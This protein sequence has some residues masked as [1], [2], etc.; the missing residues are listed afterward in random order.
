MKLAGS[1]GLSI[2]FTES[3]S[4]SLLSTFVPLL[5]ILLYQGSVNWQIKVLLAYSNFVGD[6]KFSML[7]SVLAVHGHYYLFYGNYD[8]QDH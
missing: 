6:A 8:T 4:K 3:K 5:E 7:L 2:I 1:W